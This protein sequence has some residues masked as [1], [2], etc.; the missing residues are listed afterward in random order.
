M[1]SADDTIL[2]KPSRWFGIPGLVGLLISVAGTL[3]LISVGQGDPVIWAALLVCGSLAILFLLML[4][5]GASYLRLDRSGFTVRHLFHSRSYRWHDVGVFTAGRFMITP[6]LVGYSTQ[7]SEALL[8]GMGPRQR[9]WLRLIAG[10]HQLLLG[11]FRMPAKELAATMNRWRDEA[12]R[13][14]LATGPE[15]P[16]QWPL[17]RRQHVVLAIMWTYIAV[18]AAAFYFQFRSGR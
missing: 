2:I 12:I 11:H 5:P 7:E 14:G 16:S 18:I 6:G 8:S 4:F 3:S 15:P 1:E 10:N 17:R 13:R 9:Y